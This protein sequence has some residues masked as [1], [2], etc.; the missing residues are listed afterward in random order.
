MAIVKEIT[1]W[2]YDSFDIQTTGF[3][4]CR[5]ITDQVQQ[6]VDETGIKYG[7]VTVQ[8]SNTTARVFINENESG[9]LEFDFVAAF[10]RF[11]P[12]SIYYRHD[13]FVIR[14]QN[15]NP[16]ECENGHSHCKAMLLPSSIPIILL[17]GKLRLGTWGRVMVVEL[18]RAR[19]RKVEVSIIGCME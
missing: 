4:E 15:M 14:T 5:D 18:D 7:E 11:A 8:V 6:I 1:T 12:I 2:A 9:L 17:D 16:G 19:E 3:F 10:E 13:D